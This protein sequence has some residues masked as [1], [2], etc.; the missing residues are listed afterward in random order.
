MT[1]KPRLCAITKFSARNTDSDDR[2]LLTKKGQPMWR[3]NLQIEERPGVWINGLVFSD[4]GP[5][6][7]GT[8]REL[9]LFTEQYQGRDIPKFKLPP[10]APKPRP[11]PMTAEQGELMIS[12]L[13]SIDTRLKDLCEMAAAW[14]QKGT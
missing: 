1:D 11:Q 3:V 4:P 9:V 12:T 6:W 2:P 13:Q 8:T 14:Y 5:S 10:S 7:I